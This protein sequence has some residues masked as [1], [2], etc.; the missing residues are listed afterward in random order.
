[1]IFFFLIITEQIITPNRKKIE[2]LCVPR[3]SFCRK[4]PARR[5]EPLGDLSGNENDF[6]IF[7]SGRCNYIIIF[8]SLF[9]IIETITKQIPI[10]L[11]ILKQGVK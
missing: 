7:L 11:V 10:R 4:A 6:V 2:T 5:G 1:M 9:I 3:I 8:D